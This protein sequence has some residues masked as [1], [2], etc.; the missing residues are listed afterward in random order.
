MESDVPVMIWGKGKKV[1]CLPDDTGCWRGWGGV[2][3]LL[4]KWLGGR[5]NYRNDKWARNED[6]ITQMARKIPD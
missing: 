1:R 5:L 6:E 4:V 2:R 3:E